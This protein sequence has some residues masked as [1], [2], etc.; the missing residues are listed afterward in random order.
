ML[1]GCPDPGVSRPHNK[2]TKRDS[3]AK[4]GSSKRS[5][6]DNGLSLRVFRLDLDGIG[7]AVADV[8]DKRR[9]ANIVPIRPEAVRQHFEHCEAVG[10]FA[11]A[12][13]SGD[14]SDR[15]IGQDFDSE[16]EELT[17]FLQEERR[18]GKSCVEEFVQVILGLLAR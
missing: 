1:A 8:G 7:P 11:C 2:L 15:T 6:Q 9:R 18:G 12:G 4:S 3:S 5:E 10:L 13:A 17:V 16:R 14:V